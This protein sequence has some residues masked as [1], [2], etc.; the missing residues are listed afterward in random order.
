[1]RKLF[2]A[3]I[4]AGSAAVAPA[5]SQASA[6]YDFSFTDGVSTVSGYLD[7]S[8][9]SGTQAATAVYLTSVP[10]GGLSLP[11]DVLAQTPYASENSFTL[12]G[13]NISGTL[14]WDW[15]GAGPD[16]PVWN[17]LL[18]GN[19][20]YNYNGCTACIG[21]PGEQSVESELVTFTLVTTTPLPAALPLFATGLSAMGLLGWRRKRKNT[22]AI[23]TA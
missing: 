7:F 1:M 23:A 11:F 6:V 10:F 8:S 16:D 22:A 4:L 20:E 12:N 17:L 18:G 19:N 3:F 15:E 14:Q 5:P 2:L 9:A 21:G 13:S